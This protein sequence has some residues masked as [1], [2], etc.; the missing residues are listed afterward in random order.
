MM[1]IHGCEFIFP[2]WRKFLFSPYMKFWKIININI[3]V[4]YGTIYRRALICA[5]ILSKTTA[6]FIPT[7][8]TQAQRFINNYVLIRHMRAL[9]SMYYT[10]ILAKTAFGF[11]YVRMFQFPCAILIAQT[12]ITIRDIGRD[13]AIKVTPLLLQ[14]MIFLLITSSG[15]Y[16]K[17]QVFSLQ[18]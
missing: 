5:Q 14:M 7:I 11:K 16:I 8:N 12:F 15:K 10:N 13:T 1:N 9:N 4:N 3:L 2:V 6:I 18:D 17:K